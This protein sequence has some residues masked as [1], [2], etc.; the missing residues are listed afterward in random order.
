MKWHM[1]CNNFHNALPGLITSKFNCL[2][3][4]K[5][6]IFAFHKKKRE[7]F[8][9]KL[10]GSK[11]LPITV[12]IGLQYLHNVSMCVKYLPFLLQI[13]IIFGSAWIQERMIWPAFIDTLRALNGRNRWPFPWIKSAEKIRTTT[14]S[15]QLP[16]FIFYGENWIN[17]TGTCPQTIL[18]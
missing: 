9:T 8:D 12:Q 1:F 16:W 5:F 6:S 3:I 10:R 13:L 11:I 2:Q 4:F 18:N 7:I 15:W 14:H 17:T